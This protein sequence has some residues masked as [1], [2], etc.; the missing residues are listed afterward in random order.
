MGKGGE[1]EKFNGFWQE[2][3]LLVGCD[4]EFFYAGKTHQYYHREVGGDEETPQHALVVQITITLSMG[5][6][7]L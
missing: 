5:K 6:R 7:E 1:N 4:E 3:L 2:F